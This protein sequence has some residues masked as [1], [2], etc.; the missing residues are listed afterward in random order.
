M[1]SWRKNQEI[2]VAGNARE[3]MRNRARQ[4]G[5]SQSQKVFN[6]WDRRG[7]VLDSRVVGSHQSFLRSAKITPV[8]WKGYSGCC[9]DR[10]ERGGIRHRI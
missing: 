1:W 8:P 2:N 5:G 3:E 6:A 7:L 10:L 4:A 9:G